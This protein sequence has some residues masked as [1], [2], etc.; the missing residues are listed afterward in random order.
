MCGSDAETV[1]TLELTPGDGGPVLDEEV[2]AWFRRPLPAS[3]YLPESGLGEHL[4]ALVDAVIRGRAGVEEVCV[5]LSE[6]TYGRGLWR[7][8][9]LA[10]GGGH[11]DLLLLHIAVDVGFAGL[12][13][14]A[15]VETVCGFAGRS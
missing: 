15:N 2:S 14:A 1:R 13:T 3:V 8:G 12:E 9:W 4:C 11:T 5:L 6:L 7:E 10:G